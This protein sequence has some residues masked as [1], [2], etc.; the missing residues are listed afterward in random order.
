MWKIQVKDYFLKLRYS[1]TLQTVPSNLS[2]SP[3]HIK[4]NLYG[5]F[6]RRLGCRSLSRERLL[7]PGVC[8]YIRTAQLLIYGASLKLCHLDIKHEVFVRTRRM[9]CEIMQN[10]CETTNMFARTQKFC[11]ITQI[12]VGQCKTFARNTIFFAERRVLQD[13]AK[14]F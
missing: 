8:D 1:V 9:F 7:G 14:A 10:F 5:L 3:A 2:M 12:S 11:E 13:N 4:I 6:W